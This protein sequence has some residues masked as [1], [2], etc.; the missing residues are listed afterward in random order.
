[1]SKY[2]GQVGVFLTDRG[3]VGFRCACGYLVFARHR[4]ALEA[5]LQDH[6]TTEYCPATRAD[7][8]SDDE[9]SST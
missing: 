7:T 5:A 1:M 4:A 2:P 8:A 3:N 9:V 6:Q